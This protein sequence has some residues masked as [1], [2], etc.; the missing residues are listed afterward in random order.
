MVERDVFGMSEEESDSW[1]RSSAAV[2]EEISRIVNLDPEKRTLIWKD[3]SELSFNE[4]VDRIQARHAS[5]PKHLIH[6]HLRGWLEQGELPEGLSQEELER[7]DSL[8]FDWAEQ[9][10]THIKMPVD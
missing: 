10:P 3:G 5:Q 9:I 4:S 1:F 2:D 7:L 6:A 8:V